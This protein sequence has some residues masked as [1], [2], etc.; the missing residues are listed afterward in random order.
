MRVAQRHGIPVYLVSNRWMRFPEHPLVNKVVVAEGS[1]MA[2]HWIVEHI[3]SGDIA[4]T[5]DIPLAARC[6]DRK[7]FA[8]SP[9]GKPFDEA[10][11]GMTLAMRNLMTDLRSA[12]EITTHIPSFTARDRSKF[13]DALETMV[14]KAEKVKLQEDDPL[15][16]PGN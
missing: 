10:S 8:I 15:A 1:D 14:R 6:V 3:G 11:I 13:L 5:A 12:G 4:V 2:D 7:A 9:T 16:L